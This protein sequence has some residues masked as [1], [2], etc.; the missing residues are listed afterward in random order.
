M[1]RENHWRIRRRGVGNR[2]RKETIGKED[3]VDKVDANGV[4]NLHE[5][6]K[7]WPLEFRASENVINVDGEHEFEL[8]EKSNHM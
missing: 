3:D 7:N 8:E 2:R 6:E 4:S 5:Q 1:R